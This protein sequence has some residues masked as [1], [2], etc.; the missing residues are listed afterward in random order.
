MKRARGKAEGRG[1]GASGPGQPI[2]RASTPWSRALPGSAFRLALFTVFAAFAAPLAAQNIPARLT[3]PDALQIARA[4]NP[5]YRQ[6]VNQLETAVARVRVGLG[7]FLPQLQASM[8][9]GINQSTRLTGEDDFGEPVSLP[10]PITYR[11]SSAGQSVSAGMTLFD[12]FGAVNSYRAA[13]A[14]SDAADAAVDLALRR[15]EA[16]TARRFYDALR[17]Q[18]LIAVEERLLAAARE[19]L[20]NTER[21]FRT[22]GAQQDDLL[23]AQADVAQRELDLARTVGEAEK[24]QLALKEYLGIAEPMVVTVEGELPEVFDPATLDAEALVATA[25]KANPDVRRLQAEAD[26]AH[27]EAAAV[28]GGRWPTV[29]LNA[30]LGRSMGL[31]NYGALFELNPQ[32][33][34]LGVNIGVSVPLFQRFQTS[35]QIAQATVTAENADE[36]LRAGELAV[37]RTVRSALIDLRNAHRAVALAEQAAE[38]SRQRLAFAR[39]RYALAS[40]PFVSL[41]QIINQANQTER[42]LV[43]ARFGF[44]RALV[45]LEEAVGAEVKGD[46]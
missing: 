41:Q 12:G 23:G 7:R 34:S 26:A 14:A 21:L 4:R 22:A 18:R 9:W 6:A 28:R 13:R 32:N 15:L 36:Q 29:S 30:S 11:S 5:Q 45:N 39:E 40:L 1:T 19:L 27:L 10:A 16:E 42:Q 38:L 31:S 8:G 43:E 44:A 3:L 35:A 24:A 37:D 2:G 20:A 17:A 46:G 25:L 33:R